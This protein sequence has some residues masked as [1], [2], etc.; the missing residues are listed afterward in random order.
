[1]DNLSETMS[2]IAHFIS[3][4]GISI[5]TA[6][7]FITHAA[8]MLIMMKYNIMQLALFNMLSA[9]LYFINTFIS[10]TGR[11]APSF[12]TMFIEMPICAFLSTYYLG[13]DSGFS[14]YLIAFIPAVIYFGDIMCEGAKKL[15]SIIFTISI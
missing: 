5:T 2:K 3:Y 13:W 4:N 10:L 14:Q 7:M 9:V 6:L 15:I 8:L 11:I 1:M 12:I